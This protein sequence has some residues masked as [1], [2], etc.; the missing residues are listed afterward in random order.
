LSQIPG[1]IDRMQCVKIA[2]T[3]A[4]NSGVRSSK[5]GW[6][7]CK[8]RACLMHMGVLLSSGFGTEGTENTAIFV[9]G[10]VQPRGVA[11]FK[12]A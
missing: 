1:V 4:K 10:C 12:A 11:L 9:R 7:E 8:N 3:I 6:R 2:D 5:P